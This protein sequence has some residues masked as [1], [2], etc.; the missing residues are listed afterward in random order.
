[1]RVLAVMPH[2]DRTGEQRG[3]FLPLKLM[4]QQG[5]AAT[6]LLTNETQQ[7]HD[8]ESLWGG[9]VP[10]IKTHNGRWAW[11]SK[12]GLSY[13]LLKPHLPADVVLLRPWTYWT[14]VVIL[15]KLLYGRPYVVWLDTYRY[16]RQKRL[17]DRLYHEL[18]YGIFLRN[19][20][21]IIGET[22]Q[23]AEMAARRLPGVR[24]IH[25][26]MGLHIQPLQEME[27]RWA[28][29]GEAPQRSKT[30]LYVGR[31]SPE[32]RPHRLVEVF[33]RVSEEFPDWQ[34]K[35][36]GPLAGIMGETNRLYRDEFYRAIE[37]SG[38]RERIRYAPGLYGEDLF[39]EYAASSI[40]VL[41]S[42]VEGV[43]TSILEAMY[44]GG[45]ILS[46]DTGVVSWQVGGGEAGLLVDAED[47][48]QMVAGLRRL[49]RDDQERQRMIQAAR[50]RVLELFAWEKNIVM[51][52]EELRR[53]T[54]PKEPPV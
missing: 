52:A 19:A 36:V 39:R 30:V 49:M 15:A 10:V 42:A 37:E 7:N 6:T 2:A 28:A 41:P 53:L 21:L 5:I 13:Y 27:A 40:Y 31:I 8:L 23:V 45:A 34:L 1:M 17:K 43:P 14:K 47:V 24:V 26:P 25:V 18:R 12:M 35:L 9:L 3:R 32:K 20:S 16:E 33:S 54:R 46:T 29:Q 22:P 38:C 4:A 48:S 11:W 44:F 50:R 51:L